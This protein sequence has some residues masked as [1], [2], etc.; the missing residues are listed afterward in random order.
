MRL[1]A[2]AGLI[3]VLAASGS[4]AEAPRDVTGVLA[5]VRAKHDLPAMAGAIVSAG[6]LEAVG[7][8]GVRE[9][10]KPEKATTD[11]LWHLGSCTKAMTATL[12]AQLVA[13]KKLSWTTTVGEVF[14]D[15]KTMDPAWKPVTL[16]QLVTNHGGAP[17]NLDGDGLWGRLCAHKGTPQEQRRALVEGV[18]KRPPESKPG[19]TYLYSN[20]GFSIAGAM[21]ETVAKEPY[22]TLIAKRLFEPLGMKSVGFGAPGSAA[23]VDQPRGHRADGKPVSPGAGADNPA[24]IA[25]AGRVHCTIGDWAKFVALHVRG[26]TKGGA[27]L[28]PPESFVKLHAPVADES[29]YAMGWIVTDREWAG[30]RALTHSGSNTMW[31]CTV[32]F[33]P[34]RDFAVLV[35]TNQGGDEAAKA[36]D[37]ASWALIQDHLAHAKAAGTK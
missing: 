22:E 31:Y 19:T 16:E 14:A 5:P 15:V 11:D 21:A 24:A 18:L 13:E 6:E 30:G 33:A 27:K 8:D 4:A 32:W 9:R 2:A 20:A 26:E 37:E 34:E 10:G 3:L 28:M 36:C 35:T 7:V 29:H 25:P 12:C 1:H 23:T 17:A